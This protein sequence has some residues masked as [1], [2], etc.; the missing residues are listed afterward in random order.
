M[1]YIIILLH[2][3]ISCNLYSREKVCFKKSFLKQTKLKIIRD[4]FR[5]NTYALKSKNNYVLV[6]E[7]E[8]K[9]DSLSFEYIYNKFILIKNLY[10]IQYSPYPG[11]ISYKIGCPDEYQPISNI[12]KSDSIYINS[13]TLNAN[14]ALQFGGCIS[15][16]KYYKLYYIYYISLINKHFYEIKFYTRSE[17]NITLNILINNIN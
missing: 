14:K 2:L 9:T 11:K 7:L 12:I 8:F 17:K 4:K 10:Q 13:L 3:I 5:N 15:E 1:K 6:K 16:F